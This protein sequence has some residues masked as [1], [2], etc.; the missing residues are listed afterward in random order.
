MNTTDFFNIFEATLSRKDICGNYNRRIPQV[1]SEIVGILEGAH[2]NTETDGT[3]KYLWS[4]D[5]EEAASLEAVLHSGD[6]SRRDAAV[7]AILQ[8]TG[9]RTSA[10]VAL[11]LSSID[12]DKGTIS[13]MQQKNGVVLSFPLSP[14]VGNYIRDYCI[15]ERP[16]TG[17][18]YIFLR[19]EAPHIQLSVAGLARIVSRVFEKA[20]IK[21]SSDV[22]GGAHILRRRVVMEFLK[23]HPSAPAFSGHVSHEGQ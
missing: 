8:T 16:D 4:F 12:W 23:K 6:I 1:R 14:M 20:G 11:K 21:L 17:S 3:V 15:L 5:D 10:V 22:G 13:T 19:E 2:G 9:L 18:E 7:V